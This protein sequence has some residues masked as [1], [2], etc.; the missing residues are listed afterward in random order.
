MQKIINGIAIAS[1]VVSLSIVG[2]G[3]FVYLQRDRIINAVQDKVLESVT[4]LLPNVVDKAL[5]SLPSTTG[6]V[7]GIPKL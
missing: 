2:S 5:P 6:P 3:F 1:G 7:I 4:D